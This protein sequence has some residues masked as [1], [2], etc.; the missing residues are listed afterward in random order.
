[1]LTGGFNAEYGGRISSVLDIRTREGNMKRLS[2]LVSASP[3]MARA[4]IEGPIQ[5]LEVDGGGSSSFMFS[6]KHS[7]IDQT[8]EYLYSYAESAL[9]ST[10][11]LH[12]V[13]K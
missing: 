1:M 4:V 12:Y 9:D 11:T 5:K 10:N 8:S 13:A 6:A 7:Y 3:F 2:G